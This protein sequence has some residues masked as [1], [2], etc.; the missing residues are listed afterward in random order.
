[1]TTTDAPHER[2]WLAAACRLLEIVTMWLLGAITVLI[3]AQIA[4]RDLVGVG[5]PWAEELARYCGLGLVYLALPL[6]LLQDKHVRVDM[7]VKLL[8]GAPERVVLV[9]NEAF[10]V[11]FCAFFLWGGWAFMQRASRFSTPA[12]G[13]PNWLYYLPAFVGM[14]VFTLVALLRLARALRGR[15]TAGGDAP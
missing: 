11:L 12:I 1:M 4:A 6:L 9:A 8:R 14:F 10:T 2:G 13:M 7:L 5:A 15:P 3:L